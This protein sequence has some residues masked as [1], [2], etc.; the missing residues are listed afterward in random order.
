MSDKIYNSRYRQM[1]VGTER[2]R[3]TAAYLK[4]IM[5]R[6]RVADDSGRSSCNEHA[7]TRYFFAM[8]MIPNNVEALDRDMVRGGKT[9]IP[10]QLC[11]Y[12]WAVKQI[13]CT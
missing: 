1:E 13:F 5:V 6:A 3:P 7:S 11:L 4:H 8:N 2:S 9:A 10:A 12:R